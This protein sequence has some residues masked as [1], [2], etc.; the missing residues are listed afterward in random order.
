[1]KRILLFINWNEFLNLLIEMDFIFLVYRIIIHLYYWGWMKTA[2][3]RVKKKNLL[4]RSLENARCHLEIKKYSQ[5][6]IRAIMILTAFNSEMRS[7]M[8]TD[9]FACAQIYL[10]RMKYMLWYYYTDEVPYRVQLKIVKF[11]WGSLRHA[12][13]FRQSAH[14]RS[15][16]W[17]RSLFLSLF[18]LFFSFSRH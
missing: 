2:F 17:K 12:A 10:P 7:C 9:L 16:T 13:S 6:L 4:R 8:W 1:M 14:A 3:S 5:R 18:F 15:G 11:K